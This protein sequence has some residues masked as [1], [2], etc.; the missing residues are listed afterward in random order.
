[1]ILELSTGGL[2]A[3]RA[4]PYRGPMDL[5]M[6]LR[7]AAIGL[8]A[9]LVMLMLQSMIAALGRIEPEPSPSDVVSVV[10]EALWDNVRCRLKRDD[11]A[12]LTLFRY[13]GDGRFKHA[14]AHEDLVVWRKRSGR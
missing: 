13:Y 11:H 1:M 4:V 3:R 10:G 8:G 6:R 14:G 12:T 7:G 2:L 5:R 9:G